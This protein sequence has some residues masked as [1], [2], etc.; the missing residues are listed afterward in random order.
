MKLRHHLSA[1]LISADFSGNRVEENPEAAD[2]ANS[3]S[4]SHRR[5]WQQSALTSLQVRSPLAA[6]GTQTQGGDASHRPLAKHRLP[7]IK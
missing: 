6:G 1:P 2:S 3:P 4:A 7:H 5:T